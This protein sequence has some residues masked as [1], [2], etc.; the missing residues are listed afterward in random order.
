MI[1]AFGVGQV[2][3]SLIWF[4]LFF[5]WIMLLFNVFGDLFRDKDLS[6]IAKVLWIVLLIATPYLGVFIYLIVRG[7][8]MAE[9][10]LAMVQQQDAAVR[11]YIQSAAGTGSNAGDQLA[12]IAELKQ[13]GL[14]DD[15]E[16][17]A[18]KAKILA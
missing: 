5:M 3:W 13:Q 16:Y 10:Q 4:F 2:V 11:E 12:K 6:G 15:A 8:G 18:A 1:V 7:G 9:R 14:I 17:A